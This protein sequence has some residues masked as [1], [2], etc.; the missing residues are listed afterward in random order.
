MKV[1]SIFNLLFTCSV[2]F[3]RWPFII[4]S[5]QTLIPD[6]TSTSELRLQWKDNIIWFARQGKFLCLEIVDTHS[7]DLFR[8][9]IFTTRLIFNVFVLYIPFYKKYILTREWD[10]RNNYMGKGKAEKFSVENDFE[11]VTFTWL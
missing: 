7:R 8:T 9:G 3:K 1:V 10:L 11:N 2:V 5:P 6:W 4:Y